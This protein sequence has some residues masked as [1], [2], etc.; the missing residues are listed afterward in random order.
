MLPR[1]QTFLVET[2]KRGAHRGATRAER[3][4][5]V[6][7]HEPLVGHEAPSDDGFS[8]TAVRVDTQL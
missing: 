1:D 5:Q 4:R 8:Q 3:F 7:F 6:G 2:D